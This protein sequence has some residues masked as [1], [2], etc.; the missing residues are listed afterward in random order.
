M[1]FLAKMHGNGRMSNGRMMGY[2]YS[3]HG[4]LMCIIQRT[5]LCICINNIPK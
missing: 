4:I 3:A 1:G 5:P 2:K